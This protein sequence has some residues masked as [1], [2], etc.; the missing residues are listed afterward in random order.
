MHSYTGIGE[1][2]YSFTDLLVDSH[3][4]LSICTPLQNLINT[5]V[6]LI[7]SLSDDQWLLVK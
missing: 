5:D 4:E 3:I 7:A 2:P 1:K 6:T